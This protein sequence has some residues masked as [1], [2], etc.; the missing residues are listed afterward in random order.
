M[1]QENRWCVLGAGL[2]IKDRVPIDPYRAI[3]SRV[4]DVKFL[5]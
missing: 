5:S 3:K 4:F 1:Q 2:P